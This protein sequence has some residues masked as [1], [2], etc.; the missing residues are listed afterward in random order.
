MA[1]TRD[2]VM[3]LAESL[4]ARAL[5]LRDRRLLRAGADRGDPPAGWAIRLGPDLGLPWRRLGGRRHH[6]AA[7]AALTA[8]DRRQP[9]PD[10]G[11]ADA[12]GPRHSAS[13]RHHRA[14]GWDRLRRFGVS[15]RSLGS[16]HAATDPG[17][18]ALPGH[19][20]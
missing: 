9:C 17:S 16:N 5:E 4:R 10:P 6:H 14:H 18:G 15:E 3:V 8:P 1:S 13:G 19:L 2:P 12:P 20:I 11:C 7:A